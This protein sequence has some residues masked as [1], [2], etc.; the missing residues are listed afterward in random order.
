MQEKTGQDI[1]ELSFVTAVAGV[2]S[3]APNL[4]QA[5]K[6]VLK[7]TG[8]HAGA[9]HIK[10]EEKLIPATNQ[11][12]EGESI[13]KLALQATNSQKKEN[14]NI[15][16]CH[17]TATPI[18]HA[19]RLVGVLTTSSLQP[20]DPEILSFLAVQFAPKIENT[21]LRTKISEKQE[22][23]ETAFNSL[24]HPMSIHDREF[25]I[26]QANKPLLR[27]LR[28]SPQDIEGKH[29]F[30]IIHGTN[31]PPPN[32]PYH[33]AIRT[34]KPIAQEFREQRKETVL[35][36]TVN[37]LKNQRG[38]IIGAVH[39]IEDI[40]KKKKQEEKLLQRSHE[41][42]IIREISLEISRTQD[43]DTLLENTLKRMLELTG[44]ETGAIYLLN[45]KRELVLH[46][47]KGL[48]HKKSIRLGEGLAGKTALFGIPAPINDNTS[49]EF[50]RGA[51]IPLKTG[52]KIKGVMVLGSTN[53]N[54][55]LNLGLLTSLG[56]Q[57]A[58]AIEK[59]EL[60]H[61]S[62]ER[63]S[64][65][66]ALHKVG[67]ALSTSDTPYILK[68]MVEAARK[69]IPS[70]LALITLGPKN[71][72]TLAAFSQ[73]E[74]I[75]PCQV[76]TPITDKGLLREMW[77]TGKTMCIQDIESH[78]YRMGLPQGHPP[79]RG[80]LAVPLRNQNGDTIGL[81]MISDKENGENFNEED[82]K[83]MTA[84]AGQA[85]LLLQNAMTLTKKSQEN[86]EL[87]EKVRERTQE[88]KTLYNI[89]RVISTEIELK[90]LLAKI[91]KE[92]TEAVKAKNGAVALLEETR[93]TGTT[94]NQ[95]KIEHFT[96]PRSEIP[97]PLHTPDLK[98]SNP[99]LEKDHLIVPLKRHGKII[100]VLSLHSKTDGTEFNQK[101]ENL[102][103]KIAEQAAIALENA[104]LY[105]E[106]RH[107]NQELQQ[108]DQIKSNFLST[109][110]HELRTPLTS[111]IGYSKLLYQNDLGELNEFQREGVQEILRS[112]E[113]LLN[114]INS[115]LDFQKLQSGAVETKIKRVN[116]EDLIHQVVRNQKPLANE[117]NHKIEIQIDPTASKITTDPD[118]LERILL[119]ILNNAIKFTP[120][121][122]RIRIQ[123][124]KYPQEVRISI[125]DNGI[126][127]EE[128]DREKLFKPFQQLDQGLNRRHE[129]TGLGLAIV[130][131]YIQRLGGEITLESQPGKG[132]T[133]TLKIPSGWLNYN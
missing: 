80:L 61:T 107:K 22:E 55:N 62:K 37:P 42:K 4:D 26:I 49:L 72:Q 75:P 38:E 96:H 50:Q 103:C 44:A 23:W 79:L 65:L 21:I 27:L 14:L 17:L 85:S 68:T 91:V 36:I 82:K 45:K 7:L 47:S 64:R 90:T 52:N 111:I 77:R 123:T 25:R 6:D 58:T 40:T 94:Y 104:K 89:S 43:L 114:L 95:Q 28:A 117:K 112:G 10:I 30:E 13:E 101:D 120:P 88:L 41:L 63:N 59:A 57:L 92:T 86:Q 39:L 124:K 2:I 53:P 34:G 74:N 5:L 105:Q 54:L 97:A 24:H 46:T 108:I 19:G 3:R 78:P 116:L 127:I 76:K 98:L 131:E 70:R 48:K 121:G 100:G 1:K 81:F 15:G 102:V 118:K 35:N 12:L 60:C 11:G 73:D 67:L 115:I 69:I 125:T 32:C 126:G 56:S 129:G 93:I 130:K 9:I 83:L 132:S 133:F 20:P 99:I 66:E 106:L 51:Y 110:S 109:V 84:L 128:K 87:E 71:N 18:F 33:K 8:L 113:H 29:C 31:S 122:G 16:G 119:N